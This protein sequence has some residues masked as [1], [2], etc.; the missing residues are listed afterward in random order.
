MRFSSKGYILEVTIL[1][2]IIVFTSAL[3]LFFIKS[4]TIHVKSSPEVPILNV[5]FLTGSPAP[6]EI[7]D[8]ELCAYASSDTCELAT[9]YQIGGVLYYRLPIKGT[10][11]VQL[12]TQILSD[13]VMVLG[14][15]RYVDLAHDDV[16]IDSFPLPI[17]LDEGEY[18][19]QITVIEGDISTIRSQRFSGVYSTDTF[20]VEA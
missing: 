20:E 6:L 8:L 4:G 17:D 15:T 2:V 12:E 1:V 10:T 11:V 18:I 3:I 5:Q 16:I 9:A 19:L 13:G 7:G 14:S